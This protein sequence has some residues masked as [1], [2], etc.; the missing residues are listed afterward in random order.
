MISK[1][2]NGFTS[3]ANTKEVKVVQDKKLKPTM[4]YKK[5]EEW[6]EESVPFEKFDNPAIWNIEKML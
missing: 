1:I 6:K 4:F 5:K 3:G 2:L